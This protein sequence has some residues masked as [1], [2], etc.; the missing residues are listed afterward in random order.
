VSARAANAATPAGS[1]KTA[2]GK[3]GISQGRLPTAST[4]SA[5]VADVMRRHGGPPGAST[6][7]GM[8][9]SAETAIAANPPTAA[10]SSARPSRPAPRQ[11]ATGPVMTARSAQGRPAYPSN[12]AH[13]PISSRSATNGFQA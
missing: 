12:S 11:D 3:D 9:T 13:W 2:C 10:G 6:A 5:V 7:A 1:A 4:K 8:T